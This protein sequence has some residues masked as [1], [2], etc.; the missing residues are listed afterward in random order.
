MKKVLSGKEEKNLIRLRISIKGIVQGVGFRPFIY[1]LARCYS[2]SG[3]VLNN[4]KGVDIEVEGKKE[5]VRLFLQDIELKSPPLS[6]IEEIKWE[7]LSLRGY[8]N[9][10]IKSSKKEKERFLP[11]S[12]DIS[13]CNDCLRELFDPSNRRYRYPFIN[14]TNCGPRFTIV[15]DIPY[16]RKRTT[17]SSFK[18]CEEC[19]REYNDPSNRRFHAQ[20]NACWKCGPQVRLL[21]REG[22]EIK[23]SDPILT[24][25]SLIKEGKIL[26]VKGIGGY[27]LAC[28]A[29]DPEVVEK[30]RRRKNRIDKP[31]AVMM[32]DINQVK[33]FCEVTP[34][35]ESF[36]LSP[37]RPIVLLK[38]K[39]QKVLPQEIA[40]RNKYL[41]VMLPY[42]PLH[43]L[44]LEEV[45]IPLVMTS[46]NISEE[47]IA[48]KD[49]D[50]LCR[51]K[52]IAD[53]FLVHNREIEIRVDDSVGKIV[54]GERVLIRRSRGYAPQP[55]KTHFTSKKC[56]VA[57]GSH[58]KNTFC[59]LRKDYAI[60][61]HHIGD[62]ENLEALSSLEEGIE[63]YKKIFYCMPEVVACD[64]HPNYTST[65]LAKE[66]SRKYSL[67]LIP[68]QHHHAHIASVLAEKKIDGK[69]IGV[70]FDG[71]GLGDDGSI[72]GG[73]F[74]IADMK[75]FKRIAHL[76][77]IPLP[78]GEAAI[79]EPWRM[80]LSFLY[81]IYGKE[82]KKVA[83]QILSDVVKFEKIEAVQKLIEKN[84]SSPLTSSA[85]RLFDAVSSILGI[86]HRINY[87]GQA[88][89]ELETL[90]E[91]KKES[92]YPFRIIEK[93]GRFTVDTLPIIEAI[94]AEQEKGTGL[95]VIATRF[96][97]TLSQIILE[98]CEKIRSIFSLNKVA[99]SGGVFQNTLIVRQV[100][101]LLTSSG[102]EVLLNSS[103]PPNDGG[104]SLG[105]VAVACQRVTD[106]L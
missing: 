10:E 2:L 1:N 82:G 81:Q 90:A 38:R 93:K 27:H 89:C 7:E 19:E 34:E 59:L 105:Q 76:R 95:E 102:F 39:S 54:D 87:E 16:D 5:N 65:A 57:F 30:L 32:L 64:L 31:F 49:E 35:E 42:T 14:C 70:A 58:L 69:V 13:I 12:P 40:P 77:Y 51:L 36:L 94:L 62:L 15:K 84:I 68:V 96:H 48:Y 86:R 67:L 101:H 56:I 29:T 6:V 66:Y 83:C 18:M 100:R 75:E 104:I 11:I 26:A 53:F 8:K 72:W 61:S 44:L 28:D 60:V 98:V 23:T 46:G 43:Y 73:E 22:K 45:K 92:S 85:G 80:A 3:Y 103:V 79:K 91:E 55:I 37:R 63:H 97:W 20:P 4:T 50:A 47:P 88:A 33:K 71:S 74:L 78:G 41:G 52:T 106:R 9:F 24:A 21:D 25:A 17:M 99:L